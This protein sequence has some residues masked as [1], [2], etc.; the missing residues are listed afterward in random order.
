M[1]V[2]KKDYVETNENTEGELS[3]KELVEAT[4]GDS[5]AYLALINSQTENCK[6]VY[7][8]NSYN[9]RICRFHVGRNL[10]G[11]W[12]EHYCN[13]LERPLN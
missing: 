1:A 12:Y 4:G 2:Q 9:C 5:D 10:N 11:V 6:N 3:E 8:Y 7:T 13:L